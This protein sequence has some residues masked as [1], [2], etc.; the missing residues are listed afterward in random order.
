LVQRS[1]TRK[2]VPLLI[3]ENEER[4]PGLENP[5][6][7]LVFLE[8]GGGSVLKDELILSGGKQRITL[9]IKAIVS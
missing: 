4:S 2:H 9:Q 8:N 7:R 5:G 1:G 6:E 3:G